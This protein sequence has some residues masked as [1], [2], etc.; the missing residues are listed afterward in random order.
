MASP[1]S[2][3][4]C[5]SPIVCTGLSDHAPN[6]PDQKLDAAVAAMQ[7][8]AVLKQSYQ[9]Q[10]AAAPAQSDKERIAAEGVNALTKAVTDQGLSI[11]E[12]DAILEVAQND[13]GVGEKIRQRLQPSAK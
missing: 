12:Y 3:S 8:V 1:P 6:I 4:E 9:Q 13:P 2:C 5:S 10:I 11:E 7:R